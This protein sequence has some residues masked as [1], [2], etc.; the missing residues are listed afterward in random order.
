MTFFEKIM[1]AAIDQDITNV[2]QLANAAGIPYNALRSCKEKNKPLSD[3]HKK[4]LARALKCSIGDINRMMAEARKEELQEQHEV[5][6]EPVKQEPVE[7]APIHIREEKT[8]GECIPADSAVVEEQ[9]SQETEPEL[10][11]ELEP[12]S[13]TE[14]PTEDEVL[15]EKIAEIKAKAEPLLTYHDRI[16]G[17]AKEVLAKEYAE[18]LR[19]QMLFVAV[20]DLTDL[21]REFTEKPDPNKVAAFMDVASEIMKLKEEK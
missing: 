1:K 11:P 13:M 20:A 19:K 21:C 2:N 10:V 4:L 16:K 15:E 7:S 3:A 8:I 9:P 17:M 6:A 18:M 12:Q 14:A 5:K